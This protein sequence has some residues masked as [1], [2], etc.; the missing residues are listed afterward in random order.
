[1]IFFCNAQTRVIDSLNKEIKR[2]KEDTN[3]VILLNLL[4][5]EQITIGDHQQAELTGQATKTL[6][7]KLSYKKG[8]GDWW[9]H[10]GNFYYDEGDYGRALE[11]FLNS[12]KIREE[13]AD[14]KGVAAAM[15]NMGNIYER[16]GNYTKCLDLYFKSLKVFEEIKDERG[17]AAL[18]NNIG[19]TYDYMHD[20]DKALN[21]Y[22]KALKLSETVKNK[23]TASTLMVNIGNNY[24]NQGQFQKGLEYHLNSLKIK[25]E[26]KDAK[27]IATLLT[28]IG[29]DYEQFG[30]NKKAMEYFKKALEL[31]IKIE[32]KQG[33]AYLYQIIGNNLTMQKKYDEALDN[34]LKS[35]ALSKEINS[36]I[37]ISQSEELLGR[38][39]EHKGDGLNALKHYRAHRIAR[40]SLLN[41]E[42]TKKTVRLEMN[43][44]FDK[45]EAAAKLEQQRL[46]DRNEIQSLQLSRKNYF[47]AGLISL[48]C[49]TVF[50]GWLVFRQ[51]KLKAEQTAIQLEQK[52]LRSQMNPHFIFNSLTTIE[53]FIYENQ[54]KEAG[55]YLSDFARLM[56]LILENSTVEY[57]SL[58][59][60]VKTLEYYLMLQK[61][62]LED[63]LEYTIHIDE[64]LDPEQ[65]SIPPMLTQPF[66]E[67]AIEHGF[68]GSKQT[69]KVLVSFKQLNN[70]L[71]VEV[72]DNGVGFNSAKETRDKNKMHR[73]MA[74]QITKERLA[75]LNRSKK[76]K[77]TFSVSDISDETKQTTG[78][79]VIF[80]IPL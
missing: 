80:S 50:I 74:M 58:D 76:Q 34:A 45:K 33:I 36:L 53:S 47:M 16:T 39:Y 57:I 13:R 48:L 29:M 75:V 66:I 37:D 59:K 42:N 41:E 43:F 14:R 5:S 27:G 63:G 55:R 20:F 64:T 18:L 38:V 15:S 32:D 40:D 25:E 30:D 19:N 22:F 72:K 9:N 8:M 70:Q 26:I 51:N 61:L 67:N 49:L 69:G 2:S 73:S 54:P 17:Q 56:R 6:S 78:T 35:F 10:M 60:E 44:E 1:M 23:M 77:L 52:L 24:F 62:R 12:I 4:L 31:G 68:R 71:I 46:A 79:V 28:N 7:E 65:V 11:Y 21:Y 3:K